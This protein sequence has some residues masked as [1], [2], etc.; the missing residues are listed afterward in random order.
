MNYKEVTGEQFKSLSIKEQVN[1]I[2]EALKSEGTQK[3]AFACFIN[4]N[5][6]PINGK[7]YSASFRN[8]GYINTKVS[9][10]GKEVAQFLTAKE[11]EQIPATGTTAGTKAKAIPI[12]APKEI[13]INKS[14][15]VRDNNSNNN[16][17][18]VAKGFSFNFYYEPCGLTKKIAGNI[19]S[20]VYKEFEILCNKYKFINVSGHISNAIALYI[21]QLNSK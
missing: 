7:H 17:N 9:I 10:E 5:G 18:S 6:K 1:I 20:E 8:A 14:K 19:D 21:Q 11:M 2:N 12:D 13:K 15:K 16:N 3:K 4:E